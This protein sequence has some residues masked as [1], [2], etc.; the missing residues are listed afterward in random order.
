MP[1]ED[2]LKILENAACAVGNSS[3]FVRDSSYFGTPVV[4]VGN[5]QEGREIAENV[6]RVPSSRDAIVVA[7]Q[8]QLEHGRY[9]VSTLYGDGHVADRIAKQLASLRPY[10]Q[11]KLDYCRSD[12]ERSA[13]TVDQ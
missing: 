9:P 5:R 13:S 7:A 2:Y 1:P 4:L 12:L 10:V 11:K 3:S 8:T 6:A